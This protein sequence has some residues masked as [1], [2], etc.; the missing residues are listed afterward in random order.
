MRRKFLLTD[1]LARPLGYFMRN[2]PAFWHSWAHWIDYQ[3]YAFQLLVRNDFTGLVFG[4]QLVDEV[5]SCTFAQ[6][7]AGSCAVTGSAVVAELG[8]S[9][10]N[11][12][13]YTF[14]M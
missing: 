4:C 5:C 9:G 6:S 1:C 13:L 2:L 3:T 14:L 11:D 12:V 7:D 8:Y 10:S